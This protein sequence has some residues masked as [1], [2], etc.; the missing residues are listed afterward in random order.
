MQILLLPKPFPKHIDTISMELSTLYFKGL[1]G[2]ISIKWCICLFFF[3]FF[4]ANNRWR[5]KGYCMFSHDNRE[6][7]R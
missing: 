3:F 6:T 4:A 1:L 5:F 2:R 7:D